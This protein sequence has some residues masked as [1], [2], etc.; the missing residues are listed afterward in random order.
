MR[1]RAV[2][3]NGDWTF[4]KGLNDYKFGASAVQQNI[5]TRLNSFLNDC[6]F[7]LNSGLDWYNLL[8]AKQQLPIQLGVTA[9]ILNTQFVT[10]LQNAVEL[11]FNAVTRE[12]SLTY[13][14]NTA[15]G[16]ISA[17]V[18][19]SVQTQYLITEGGQIITTEGGSGLVP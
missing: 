1:T 11:D 2:N 13:S 10:R 12:L 14:C 9:T 3:E 8:G 18:Q 17:T 4:G 16:P 19:L 7:A 15:F 6:F 5:Q